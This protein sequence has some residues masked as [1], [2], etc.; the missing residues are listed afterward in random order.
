MKIVS[1]V[2]GGPRRSDGSLLV[3]RKGKVEIAEPLTFRE[4]EYITVL[5]KSR[6]A[7]IVSEPVPD[8]PVSETRLTVAESASGS[9]MRVRRSKRKPKRRAA[10]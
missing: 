5:V 10:G 6:L 4:R 3:P 2:S 7:E 1:K 9:S 8:G